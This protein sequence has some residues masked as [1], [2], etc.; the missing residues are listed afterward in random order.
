MTSLRQQIKT[1]SEVIYI[2]VEI[3][4]GLALGICICPCLALWLTPD[5]LNCRKLLKE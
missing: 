1:E 2:Y 4:A 5:L 3:Q